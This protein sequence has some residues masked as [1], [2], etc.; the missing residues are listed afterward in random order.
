MR[1]ILVVLAILLLTG[2]TDPCRQERET[3]D[4]FVEAP[5][6][7]SAFTAVV[8]VTNYSH[9]CMVSGAGYGGCTHSLNVQGLQ[10]QTRI[11]LHA[12]LCNRASGCTKVN[13]HVSK[14]LIGKDVRLA[15]DTE[16]AKAFFISTTPLEPEQLIKRSCLVEGIVEC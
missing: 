14:D 8:T 3:F 1:Y 4:A 11:Q 6:T 12:S 10:E 7:F 13:E 16:K 2:C 15:C 5:E 9:G